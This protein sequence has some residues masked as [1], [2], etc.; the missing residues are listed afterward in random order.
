MS[1]SKRIF[2]LRNN[3]R[4]SRDEVERHNIAEE[5]RLLL[6]EF[7]SSIHMET[8]I[9]GVP[10]FPHG[11]YS[12]FI[13]RGAT[14]GYN[15]I[16]FQQVTLGSNYVIGSKTMGSPTLG[17]NVYIGAGA[18]IIGRVFIGNNVIIGANATVVTDIP[19]NSVVVGTHS[20]IIH[21][22][23]VDAR[24]FSKHE[25]L[26]WAYYKD[27]DWERRLS[28]EEYSALMAADPS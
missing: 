7:G 1:K 12:V 18:K 4:C 22:E 19:D 23:R 2:D 6:H 14:I 11:P 28:E 8:K 27:G 16:I 5:Y 24:Y 17:D 10:F 13:S 21:R 9:N 26:G 15:C 25:K 20:R 3:Y